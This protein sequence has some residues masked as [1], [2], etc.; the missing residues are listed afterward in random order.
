MG[1]I[2]HRQGDAAVPGLHVQVDPGARH[3][4]FAAVAQQVVDDPPQMPSVGL[5]AELV[6]G[7]G[8]DRGCLLYTSDGY[9]QLVT[10]EE[11][12]AV[13]L[14]R[15]EQNTYAPCP[16]SLIHIWY[17]PKQKSGQEWVYDL[18][19]Y[20]IESLVRRF[21]VLELSLIHISFSRC[22]NRRSQ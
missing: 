22:E 12:L 10:D 4:V 13:R 20:G 2:L 6:A 17:I 1:D 7:T 21:L 16:L 15:G 3:G 19:F 11:F 14:R 18:K 9:P 5:H 8:E